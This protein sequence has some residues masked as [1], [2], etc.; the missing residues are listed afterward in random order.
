LLPRFLINCFRLQMI[1]ASI[2]SDR[3]KV[4]MS[5]ARHAMAELVRPRALS[6]SPPPSCPCSCFY[7]H[8][9]PVQYF[10][11]LFYL[12]VFVCVCLC[13]AAND[14][15]CFLFAVFWSVCVVV[16]IR[17]CACN[18]V[19]A[20]PAFPAV[21]VCARVDSMMRVVCIRL[22]YVRL[23]LALHRSVAIPA[24]PCLLN[25]ASENLHSFWR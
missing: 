3:L 22:R 7:V 8:P 18:L 21:Y 1:S 23:S 20:M 4:N 16:P 5:V 17:I 19:P 6:S 14:S 9:M 11:Q 2:I 15:A 12:H 10:M 25:R 13:S 24:A